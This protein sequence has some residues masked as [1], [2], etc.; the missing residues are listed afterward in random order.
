MREMGKR[1]LQKI[2]DDDVVSRSVF[3][4]EEGGRDES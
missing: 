3:C 1:D 2:D 4:C